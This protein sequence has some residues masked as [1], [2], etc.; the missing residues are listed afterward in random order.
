MSLDL[1]IAEAYAILLQNPALALA[2]VLGLVLP[3]VAGL[4]GLGRWIRRW[5]MRRNQDLSFQLFDASA[6]PRPLRACLVVESRDPHVTLDLGRGPLRLGEALARL[7]AD[8]ANAIT[9]RVS[10]A[11][12][13]VVDDPDRGIVLTDLSPRGAGRVLVNGEVVSSRQLVDGD[14]IQLGD[15]RFRFIGVPHGHAL[16]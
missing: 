10:G 13:L 15:Q 7:D 5:L 1:L 3:I 11:D 6:A 8:D 16:A 2:L 14:T 12:A 4:F 9:R